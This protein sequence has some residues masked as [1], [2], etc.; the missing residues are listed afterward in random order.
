MIVVTLL[1][2]EQL[3]IAYLAA[4]RCTFSNAE[5]SVC[6]WGAHMGDA[7]SK[8]GLTNA[9]Q[10]LDLI[11]GGQTV[12]DVSFDKSLNSIGPGTD[13][14]NVIFPGDMFIKDYSQ[15][16]YMRNLLYQMVKYVVTMTEG[17]KKL[18][19]GLS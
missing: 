1:L 5:I 15:I 11:R 7:Y 18:R 14:M 6:R 9:L 16:L 12:V 3:F 19:D 10:Q 4:V 2:Q 17:L 8:I 13:V